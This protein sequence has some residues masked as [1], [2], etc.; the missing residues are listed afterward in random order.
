MARPTEEEAS[1]GKAA[2]QISEQARNLEQGFSVS[3]EN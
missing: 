1:S 2:K 3:S